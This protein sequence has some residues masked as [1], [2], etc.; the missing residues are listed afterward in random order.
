[1]F[2]LNDVYFACRKPA[3]RYRISERS[4]STSTIYRCSL[5]HR[6]LNWRCLSTGSWMVS[7]RTLITMV[8][9]LFLDACLADTISGLE[10]AKLADLP[11]DVLIEGHRVAATLTDSEK[12]DEERS[13]TNKIAIRRKALLRVNPDRSDENN[14]LLKSIQMLD[15][16]FLASNAIGSDS[17]ALRTSRTGT[18]RISCPTSTGYHKSVTGNTLKL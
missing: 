9:F 7:L 15:S 10:L 2:S 6:P 18:T 13:Q 16:S 12:R 11:P 3:N 14:S 5:L 17:R 4:S 8:W 1:M